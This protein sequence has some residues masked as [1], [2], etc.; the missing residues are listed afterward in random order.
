VTTVPDQSDAM[1]RRRLLRPVEYLA[2]AL[3][4]P[5]RRGLAIPCL[6]AVYVLIWTLYGMTANGSQNLTSNMFET[7][8]WSRELA[9]GF[10]KHPPLA[11]SV[12][13]VWFSLVPLSDFTFYVLGMLIAGAGL[14]VA[15]LLSADFLDGYKR[16]AGLA[17]LTLI[18]F[19]NFHAL[20]YNINT[21][22]IP[23]WALTTLW[24]LRSYITGDHVYA[25]LAGLGAAAGLLGKYWTI[26]LILGLALAV[27][28]D[29][30]RGRY[31]SSATPWI[32]IVIGLM[33]LGPHLIWLH[34]DHYRPFLEAFS[35][36]AI[37]TNVLDLPGYLASTIALV[38]L[39]IGIALYL[40]TF[41]TAVAHDTAPDARR[42]IWRDILF[43]SAPYRRFI[44]I[45]FWTPVLLPLLAML[46]GMVDVTASWTM[47]AWT[48][49][50]IVLLSSPK[51]VI[52]RQA[53]VRFLAIAILF[54]LAML[55]LSPAIAYGLR[56]SGVDSPSAA[57][58]RLLAEAVEREWKDRSDRP[59][60]IVGGDPVLANSAATYIDD[61]P[62][63]VPDLA[64][65]D[66]AELVRDGTV[67]V[68][69]AADAPCIATARARLTA[70]QSGV[71]KAYVVDA[72]LQRTHLGYR[73]TPRRYTI[74]IL[75]PQ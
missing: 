35:A 41:K 15:W 36:D 24:F 70:L 68:C 74:V 3:V 67:A 39:P 52:T 69:Y 30:R 1:P 47:P 2:D 65:A 17:L 27:L 44:A 53:A 60:M 64:K 9:L 73:G 16:V 48:L 13:Q 10:L 28:C 5:A 7:V 45:V 66:T 4:D 37:T 54:P 22:L 14:W 49:L 62:R 6:L 32:T 51:I 8:A 75:P 12:V 50:A 57:H 20:R 34:G 40:A 61:H 56:Q 23:I 38:G 71:V 63:A 25:A 43:P 21:I 46:A 19:F 72:E 26:F 29:Q 11:A 58:A 33:A 59:I 31:L 55:I 18:P 42:G